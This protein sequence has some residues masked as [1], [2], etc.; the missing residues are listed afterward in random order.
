MAAIVDPSI[1][2]GY[3]LYVIIYNLDF[4]VMTKLCF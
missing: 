4:K 3:D 2:Y 1:S